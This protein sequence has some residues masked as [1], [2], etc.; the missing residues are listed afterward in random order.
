MNEPYNHKT[1]SGNAIFYH[2]SFCFMCVSNSF[3]H[4]TQR[5]GFDCWVEK[6]YYRRKTPLVIGGSRTR[7]IMDSIAIAAS[8]LTYAPHGYPSMQYRWVMKMI[9]VYKLYF[10]A[11]LF[12]EL[13]QPVRQG[14]SFTFLPLIYMICVI[15][16]RNFNVIFRRGKAVLFNASYW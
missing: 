9:F 2:F 13:N 5:L 11:A 4:R 7:V 15:T 12:H 6:P 3:K 14:Y 1:E 16:S 10:K 8:V